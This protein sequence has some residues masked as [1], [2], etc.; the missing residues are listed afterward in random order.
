MKIF[1]FAIWQFTHI[2]YNTY[3]Y[4]VSIVKNHMKEF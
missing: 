2:I 4:I 1:S 3:T